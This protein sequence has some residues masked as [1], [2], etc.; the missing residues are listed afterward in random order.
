LLL[1]HRHALATGATPGALGLLAWLARAGTH[2]ARHRPGLPGSLSKH[3][4][5]GEAGCD[6]ERAESE[7]HSH[8]RPPL[9]QVTDVNAASEDQCLTRACEYP[10]ASY[11][12][13]FF[14]PGAITMTT[15]PQREAGHDD[16]DSMHPH[17]D[18]GG[19]FCA[20][21][22]GALAD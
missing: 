1:V 8:V 15:L 12:I 16:R 17:H 13:A 3:G 5:G 20:L 22:Q 4:S 11:G 19:A 2:H 14:A 18:A 10:F 6:S 21:C 7:F 9:L